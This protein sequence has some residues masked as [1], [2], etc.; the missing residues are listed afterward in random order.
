MT[1]HPTRPLFAT[2]AEDATVAVWMLSED[3]SQVSNAL[4]A[5]Q[6]IGT[7]QY[8]FDFMHA[9]QEVLLQQ[10]AN[11]LVLYSCCEGTST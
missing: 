9:S 4:Q 2:A 6:L 11:S 8:A 7:C 3:G 10:F 5:L 1:A